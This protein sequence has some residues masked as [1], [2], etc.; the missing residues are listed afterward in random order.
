MLPELPPGLDSR[1]ILRVPKRHR[2]DAIQEAWLAHVEGR[3]PLRAIWR[4]AK[5]EYR[6]ERRQIDL[7]QTSGDDAVHV[8]EMLG[9]DM[10]PFSDDNTGQRPPTQ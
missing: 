1:H 3:D 6:H 2:E 5:Q 4:Y 10:A 9:D 7:S 8:R